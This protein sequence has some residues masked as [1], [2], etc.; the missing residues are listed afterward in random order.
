MK[1]IRIGTGAGFQGD[2]IEPAVDLAERGELDFL[3]F[4]CL[5]ERTIALSQQARIADP[6]GGYDPNLERRM[7]AILPICA[8]NGTRIVSN[9]GAAN[10]LAAAERTIAIARDL[11]LTGLKVAA[12]TGDDV[13]GIIGRSVLDETRAPA[14]ELGDRLVSANAYIGVTG[15]I[16]A[17][18]AGAD[19]VICGRASDPTLFLA[20]LMHE[21]GWA[22]D[23]V[24]R[25][26]RGTLVGHMLECAAQVT[27]G[28]FADPGK[29]DVTG[30]AQVG[31]PFAEVSADGT[32]VLSKLPGTGG[33]ISV[34]S[35]TEQLLYEI[36]DPARY[37]QP[38]VV[39]D[40]SGVCFNEIGP[41]S[42]AM[43]GADGAS[44]TGFLKVSVGYLDGWIGEG[45]ISYAGANCL[46]R[47]NMAISLMRERL[48]PYTDSLMEQRGELIG[49]NSVWPAATATSQPT[50]VRMRYAARCSDAET[51]RM[52]GEEV[53]GLYLAGPAGG[54][55]VTKGVRVCLAIA[56]T[57]L[58]ASQVTTHV[59]MMEV[60]NETA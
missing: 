43:S 20:P 48:T 24:T 35:C 30:L 31:Y 45:Q 47:G 11:G 56:S 22:P 15:L 10:P 59:E 14:A 6:S 34:A 55:G 3:V 60:Q 51:A 12:V 52:I 33:R 18:S 58:P 32:A 46:A 19:V 57:L 16:E 37:L 38:D 5:G 1:T 40:F 26:G 2:R 13:T 7:R 29:K 9:M 49:V 28:Y 23:D 44:A 50:E 39:A 42:I 21:F 53:E 8:R 17:L 54:G 4:E 36:H 27:G 25:L 41:D